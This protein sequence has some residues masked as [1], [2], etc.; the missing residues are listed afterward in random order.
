MIIKAVIN[1]DN[2][3]A[4]HRHIDNALMLCSAFAGIEGIYVTVE[5][6]GFS[7]G[8]EVVA[9][10]SF[11]KAQYDAAFYQK[12]AGGDKLICKQ[13]DADLTKLSA[14]LFDYI[15]AA[16]FGSA[17]QET[18]NL[19]GIDAA[20]VRDM[21]GPLGGINSDT[22]VFC[23]GKGHYITVKVLHSPAGSVVVSDI[24][25][26][27]KDYVYAESDVTLSA[28]LLD[29]LSVRK[30]TISV[31]ESLT[32]GAVAKALIDNPGA[33]AAVMETITAYSNDSK[34]NRLGVSPQTI[35][36]YGAVSAETAYQMAAGL[37]QTPGT[38]IAISTTGIAG[39]GGGT[40]T[41]PVGLTF[42]AVGSRDAIHVYKHIFKGSR[43]NIRDNAAGA[44][45]FYACKFLKEGGVNYK[46]LII[47]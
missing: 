7:G 17:V 30:K 29:L 43:T 2:Y 26:A 3:S 19:F 10:G 42:I 5:G 20:G 36:L 31:A 11:A 24:F 44:A 35:S 28:R 6:A 23:Y 25:L 34:I 15:G 8:S 37:L 40:M 38:D 12:L 1:T 13:D 27:V 18:F 16:L 22:A 33:S 41:K 14:Q 47:N 46:Q 21:L 4:A 39:P 9:G 45:M 32:G